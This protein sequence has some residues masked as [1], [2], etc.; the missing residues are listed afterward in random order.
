MEILTQSLAW[1]RFDCDALESG[2]GGLWLAHLAGV[3]HCVLD[4]AH[5]DA[6]LIEE[7]LAAAFRRDSRRPSFRL[8]KVEVLLVLHA[9]EPYYK[10]SCL[11]AKTRF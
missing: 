5:T 2:F 7:A 4:L 8:E 11:A 1:L 10:K 9:A 6:R 3:A